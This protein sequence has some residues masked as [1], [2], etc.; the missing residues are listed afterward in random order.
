VNWP[1]DYLDRII[2]G[3]S[4]AVLRAMPDNCVDAVITDPPYNLGMDYG[5]QID[6]GKSL[7]QFTFFVDTMLPLLKRVANT[8]LLTPGIANLGIYLKHKPRWILAWHKPFSLS[9]CPV[10]FNNWEPVLFWGKW[11]RNKWSDYIYAP[12][13][14]SDKS[15]GAHACPKP[16]NLMRELV[17]RYSKDGA[18]I[19]DPFCGSGTTLVAAKQ[20]GR[21]WIGVD[22]SPEYCE[23]ARKRIEAVLL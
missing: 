12:L 21:H 8:I 1:D 4:L 2:C 15:L 3:D 6:D 22:I 20:L 23:I 5:I 19:F 13:N 17:G 16:I 11:V 9:H 7:D 18:I 10:G 14:L